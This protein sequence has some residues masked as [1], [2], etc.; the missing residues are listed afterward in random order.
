[1]QFALYVSAVHWFVSTS[2]WPESKLKLT[3]ILEIVQPEGVLSYT[4]FDGAFHL[5]TLAVQKV[6]I[7]TVAV[8][9]LLYVLVN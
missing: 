4:M 5:N 2:K 3:K 1:M 6:L 7:E 8:T 9:F